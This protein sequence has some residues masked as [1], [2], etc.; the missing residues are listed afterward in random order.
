[1][2]SKGRNK[3]TSVVALL[4]LSVGL[5]GCSNN[6][7]NENPTPA[8]APA[9]TTLTGTVA[10]GG[11]IANGTITVKDVT[12][13]T[14]QT[15]SDGTG[16]Y[17]ID[18]TGLTGPF[19]LQISWKDTPTTTKTLYGVGSQ[20]GTGSFVVNIHPLTDVIIRQWYEAQGQTVESAFTSSTVPA[21]PTATQINSFTSEFV[22]LVA[23]WLTD[24]GLDHTTFDLITTPFMANHTGFDHVLDNTVFTTKAIVIQD[25]TTTPTVTQHS[26]YSTASS[27]NLTI[28]TATGR[29]AGTPV[30]GQ[31][32]TSCNENITVIP[33]TSPLQS[34][35]DGV[36]TT[37]QQLATTVNAKNG[38]VTVNDLVGFFAPN[39]LSGGLNGTQEARFYETNFQGVTI[40]S[41]DVQSIT[42]YDPT[43]AIINIVCNVNETKG[44]INQTRPL[45][46]EGRG[47]TFQK[48]SNGK[49]L[50]SGDQRFAQVQATVLTEHRYSFMSGSGAN[51]VFDLLYL[52]AG[53]PV[54]VEGATPVAV[55]ASASVTGDES[56]V[57]SQ[58]TLHKNSTLFPLDGRIYELYHPCNILGQ[59]SSAVPCNGGVVAPTFLR[60][61]GAVPGVDYSFTVVP[62]N[63]A[64][65]T[66]QAIETLQVMTTEPINITQPTGHARTDANL[67]KPLTV[68]WTLPVTFGINY[69][70]VFPEVS[71]ANL[72][73]QRFS[74]SVFIGILPPTATSATFTFPTTCEGL[75]VGNNL[76]FSN[77]VAE[78]VYFR[79]EV[80]GVNGELTQAVWN[81][82]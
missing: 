16:A 20:T 30:C 50:F 48:Q 62:L 5:T 14:K 46:Q 13:K 73:G 52:E 72:S 71:A 1:M 54:G 69:I 59:L 18:V 43:Q 40:N 44:G 22:N 15:T 28:Q 58:I 67:G 33:T 38:A 70:L 81:F 10:T 65:G 55:I 82:Q 2:S 80:W 79:V 8:P 25:D 37:L 24:N 9:A 6:N 78:V 7:E 76:T 66:E 42:S 32:N 45:L 75:P 11:P 51:G 36:R 57:P 23:K 39:F 19:L 12:G 49:W 61:A 56:P 41:F 77:D 60:P 35:L 63:S 34:A 74:C 64:L 68:H 4:M 26:T 47:L 17:T 27:G 3:L 29:G 21:P 31:A 53:T